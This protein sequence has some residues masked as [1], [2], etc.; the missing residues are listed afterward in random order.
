MSEMIMEKTEETQAASDFHVPVMRQ[1][2]VDYLRL[3]G[4]GCFVDCTLGM[5]GHTRSAAAWL[6]NE[7]R[8]IAID[9]DQES[10]MLAQKN[11]ASCPTKITFVHE[12]FRRVDQILEQQGI[13]EVDGFLFD[14]GISSFQLDNPERGFS[15][16]EDGPLDMRMDQDMCFSAY[17]LINSLSEKEISSILKVYGEE[18]FH[19]RIARYLV[20]ERKRHLIGTTKELCDVV[21]R[22]LPAHYRR[23]KIHP[24]TRTFQ[25][26]RI[27]VNRE[28]EAL[29]VAL[30]KSLDLLKTGGRI[31]VI[32]FH[33]LEDRIVKVN[34][35]AFAKAQRMTVITPKPLWPSDEEVAQNPRA[36]SARLRVGEKI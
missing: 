30:T 2:V 13:R 5:G 1:E 27:A 4:G 3:P 8:I 14:L 15:F 21:L 34:F 11:L 18:R 36:R 17:D 22:A 29:E 25:A 35:R 6:G 7:G 19:N 24:A 23:Q 31:C 28:L 16:R 9:R 33:S 12:D 26:F 20:N 32:S 10:L